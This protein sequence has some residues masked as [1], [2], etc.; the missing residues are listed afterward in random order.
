MNCKFS[1]VILRTTYNK[2]FYKSVYLSEK[3]FDES[4]LLDKFTLIP[5][6]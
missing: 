1:V 5:A 3:T 6:V 2:V 4:L